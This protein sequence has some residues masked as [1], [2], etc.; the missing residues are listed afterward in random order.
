MP[1]S[2]DRRSIDGAGLTAGFHRGQCHT[3]E[4]RHRATQLRLSAPPVCLGCRSTLSARAAA[5]Q[6]P[7]GRG[8]F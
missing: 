1:S 4:T 2:D 6:C 8:Q 5:W 7:D 3:A